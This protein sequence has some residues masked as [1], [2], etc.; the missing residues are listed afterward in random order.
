[1]KRADQPLRAS[2]RLPGAV[3]SLA[4]ATLVDGPR[5]R[6]AVAHRTSLAWQL[7]DDSGHCVA[8][9]TFPGALRL[10]HALALHV[11]PDLPESLMIGD[12]GLHWRGHTTPIARWWRP[13]RP[14]WPALRPVI[15]P[16]AARD[17]VDSWHDKLGQ[18]E[19][20]TPYADDV[21][22]GALVTLLAAEHPLGSVLASQVGAAAL[23]DRTTAASAGLL[24]QAA[25]GWCLDEVAAVIAASATGVGGE[26]AE[27][28]LL[29]VGHSS[30]HGLLTGINKT[31]SIRTRRAVA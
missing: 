11:P 24:R 5:Q 3:A 2:A 12:G 16:V 23:E 4:L 29:A 31:M 1:M 14:R 18:G 6:L 27:Q 22:C 9:L 28:R 13:A 30:G 21:V 20:L 26:A 10:P 7:S 8:C 15:D 25:L 17:I 19:G